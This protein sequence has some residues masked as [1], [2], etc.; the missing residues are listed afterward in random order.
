MSTTAI[1]R[2]Q[3]FLEHD[4]GFN[5]VESPD[6]L[7]A[8][9]R[10]L[11]QRITG[12]G[13][14]FPELEM[15][16]EETLALIHTPDHIARVAAT[17]G[18]PFES[19]DPDTGTSAGSY[20]AARLAAGAVV[21]GC[22]ML[23]AGEADAVFAL[24]RPPGHHAEADRAKGFCLFNNVAV[25]AASAI[26]DLGLERVLIIDW[27][28][29]HG[30]GTQHSFYDT[31]QVLYFST[32]MFPYY[33]GTGALQEIGS[34]KGR[35]FNVNVPLSGGQSDSSYAAIFNDVLTPIARQYKP[36]MILV[37]AGYDIYVEDPLGTMAVSDAGFG[38]MTRVVRTLADEL[39]GGRL[40]LTLEGGY[41][42]KGLRDGVLASLGELSGTEFLEGIRN[43]VDVLGGA[44][45][46]NG[47]LPDGALEI[48]RRE[49]SSFW[50]F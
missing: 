32:H 42:L 5:H 7:E 33:P 30:N 19:L 27:D 12:E 44:H 46:G 2:D 37:S 26:H 31:D 24:V 47:R 25:G 43:R 21:Q 50:D 38:Y 34:G 40:L 11:D 15:A 35:G 45:F 1:M 36:E 28:L 6:R 41:N 4:P 39:C 13:F 29:H 16:S 22:R 14:V 9:Y 8:I 20:D 10:G 3:R 18:R 23:S 48:L 49:F 17:A